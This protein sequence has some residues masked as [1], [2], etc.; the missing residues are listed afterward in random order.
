MIAMGKQ[1]KLWIDGLR[2]IAMI[3]VLYGHLVQ[4]VTPYFTFTSPIK[5]PLFFAVTGYVFNPVGGVQKEFYK[6]LLKGIIIPWLCL[7]A[8]Y[9]IISG[10]FKGP[11]YMLNSTVDILIGKSIW[12]MPC[13]IVGEIIWFYI[14]KI[15]PTKLY[16]GIAATVCG[17]AG[18]FLT[19]YSILDFFMINRALHIQIFL[20]LGYL[21]KE[22]ESVG[23][24]DKIKG[25]HIAFNGIVYFSL[26]ALSFFVIFPNQ[27]FDVHKV[28][29]Y[30]VPYCLLLILL[31]CTFAFLVGKR[32]GSFGAP[33]TFIGQNTLVY[34]ILG[35]SCT[36]IADRVVKKLL[37]LI[38]IRIMSPYIVPLFDIVIGCLMAAV[39]A[40][41]LTRYFPFTV[42]KK[43]YK[44]GVS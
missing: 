8:I 34:Y 18:Y 27:A 43:S 2:G 38:Q 33:L 21:F 35:G 39:I 14:R 23:G 40:V 4:G 9:V 29:Y 28:S 36:R 19:K 15:F 3:L 20:L 44:V 24:F 25:W 30:H 42:G 32:L 12:Y 13:I 11:A 1:R 10:V 22:Y 7:S 37:S 17:I 41:I 5:I 26:C 31:G 16:I 6:K